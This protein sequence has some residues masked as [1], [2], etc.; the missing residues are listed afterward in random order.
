L[1]QNQPDFGTN[2]RFFQ[3]FYGIQSKTA[4]LTHIGNQNVPVATGTVEIFYGGGPPQTVGGLAHD[5]EVIM[6]IKL[7][8]PSFMVWG[9]IVL[10]L[11]F[12]GCSLP[13]DGIEPDS[14]SFS[15]ATEEGGGEDSGAAQETPEDDDDGGEEPGE[16]EEPG[17]DPLP[18]ELSIRIGEIEKPDEG[19]YPDL[20]GI[21]RY[22]LDFSGEEGRTA[23]SRYLEAEGE[24]VLSLDAGLW[25]IRAAGLLDRGAGQPPLAVIGG[26]VRVTVPE[27]GT[28]TVLIVPGPVSGS[29][30]PGFLSW[31]I[32]YPEEK[33]WGA[34]LT[35]SLQIN[36]DT[37]IPYTQFDIRG[38]GAGIQK[39]SLPPGTYRLETRFL[40]HNEET[41]SAELVHILPGLE[42]GSSPVII[43]ETAFSDPPE[44]LSTGG[45]K[46]YLEGLSENTEANPYPVKMTGINLASTESTGETLKTLY[47]ALNQRYVTLD[48]RGCTGTELPAA[49]TA[50]LKNRANVVSLILPDSIAEIISNGFSGYASLKFAVLPKVG[51]LHYSAFKGCGQLEA[52]FAPELVTVNDANNNDNTTGA[53]AGCAALKAVYAPR[54][55]SLG[56]Y[57]LYGCGSLTGA[58]FP[59]VRTVG[60]LAFKNCTALK[61]VSLPSVI[62]IDG[63]GFENT[64][65]MFLICGAQPP[66]LG[67]GVF[68]NTGFP[69][70][71]VIYV[72]PD[73]VDTYT[74]TDLPNWSGLKGLVQALPD[75][76][77]P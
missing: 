28:E 65:L 59:N 6:H 55:A 77:V 39:I 8:F 48:L 69:Q 3:F 51:I 34:A 36:E 53:F 45:L 73:A 70:T 75:P 21:T 49:S 22:R 50:R 2:S 47:A 72:P 60:G 63:N 35:V 10:L 32:T 12:A 57:G 56:R 52:L 9:S 46:T 25:E 74:G 18:G 33:V 44:F 19:I 11:V 17:Q 1:F 37:V 64:G 41:G 13:A 23:E 68:N 58:A 30:E 15:Q 66:E 16:E 42:T 31:N 29:G 4:S 61:A 20:S 67:T 54:L 14:G 24:L 5:E 38:A 40:F 26:T 7:R 43:P 27:D 71:G 62:K 76:A